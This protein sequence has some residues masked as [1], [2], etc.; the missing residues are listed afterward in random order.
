MVLWPGAV[1]TPGGA[2]VTVK[3]SLVMEP[4]EAAE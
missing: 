2:G 4:S 3:H 1:V